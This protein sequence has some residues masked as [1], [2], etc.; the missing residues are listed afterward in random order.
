MKTTPEKEEAPDAL[1]RSEAGKTK[2]NQLGVLTTDAATV[3][4]DTP[5]P[6]TVIGQV[7]S[8]LRRGERLTPKDAW[9]R[10]GTSRLA[11]VIHTLQKD[12]GWPIDA[13]IIPVS[14]ADHRTA[15]VARYSMQE[16]A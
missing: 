10:F 8:A 3:K 5:K 7:F 9:L 15:H 16:A 4:R 6:G 12:Y 1:A 11:A 13:E 14:T 2:A